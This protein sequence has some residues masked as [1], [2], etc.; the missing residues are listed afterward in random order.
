MQRDERLRNMEK[1]KEIVATN[2]QVDERKREGGREEECARMVHSVKRE[3]Y[4]AQP[5]N[6]ILAKSCNLHNTDH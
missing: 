1:E 6:F 5:K 2:S 4:S 3:E